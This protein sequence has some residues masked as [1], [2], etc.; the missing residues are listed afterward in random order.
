MRLKSVAVAI[1]GLSLISGCATISQSRF[2]PF[3]WFGAGQEEETLSP[4][5]AESERRPLVAQIT[6][7]VIERTP[8]GAIV[9]ATAL[10]TSQGWF[11]PELVSVDP[12]GDPIDGVLSYAFRAVPPETP[13]RASTPQSRELSAAVFVP[14]LAL[15]RVRVIQ[16]TGALNSQVA[17]R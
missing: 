6:A 15:N 9:R 13:Q 4:V 1:V 10:P 5:A 2:N 14:N 11:A 16:V 8:G 7:L 12:D 17:R 3:N